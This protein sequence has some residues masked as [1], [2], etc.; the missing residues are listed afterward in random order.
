MTH[1]TV[2]KNES[3]AVLPVERTGVI[4]DCT[5]GGGGHSEA[6]LKELSAE[7]TL[8]SLDVDP[9]A[10]GSSTSTDPRHIHL[11]ANFRDIVDIAAAHKLTPVIGILADLGWRSEQ[12]EASKKGFSFAAD[13]PLLMTFGDPAAHV[14]TAHDVVNTW[15]EENLADIIYGYG[16]ERAA[17]RIAKAIVTARASKDIT[18]A[19]EL[20]AI[21]SEAIP[22]AVVRSLRIHPA[23][24]TF[25]AIRIAVND[26]LGA[27]KDLLQDGFNLLAPGGR[28]AIITFHSLEDRLV[29][30]RFRALAHDHKATLV[31]KKPIVPTAEEVATNPRARSAKLRVIEK[32]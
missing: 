16:E 11:T 25:Q 26:E 21:V 28:L 24:K 15:E 7:S 4:V 3:I 14:F 23:T 18:T 31:T 5:Y 9:T 17:R 22:R 30:H 29:K 8:V 32:L 27:L 6:I 19:A 12:F 13:E 20:A 2:L 10:L 1:I